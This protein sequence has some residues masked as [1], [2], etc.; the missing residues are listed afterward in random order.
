MEPIWIVLIVIG[1]ILLLPL[2]TI[3]FH[4]RIV[5]CFLYKKL[6]GR[7]AT[8]EHLRSITATDEIQL[9]EWH[10]GF[11]FF[12]RIKDKAQ[13]VSIVHDGLTLAGMYFDF[14]YE[15]T[16][17]VVPGRMESAAYSLYF[18]ELYEGQKVNLL[19]IDNRGTG[20]S[21]GSRNTLGTKESGDLIEW[22]KWLGEKNQKVFLHGICIGGAQ[23]VYALSNPSCPNNVI[24]GLTEGLFKEFHSMFAGHLTIIKVKEEP[25]ST[26]VMEKFKKYEG[27][28]VFVQC[29]L[30]AVDKIKVPMRFIQSLEDR[31]ILPGSA[32]ELCKKCGSSNKDFI[33]FPYGAHS[34]VRH[35]QKEEYDAYVLAYLN[36]LL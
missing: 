20:Y 31:F 28:D 24:G 3:P 5:A 21:E 16:V 10:E 25:T 12:E 36:S 8:D 14:G 29:P 11:R 9:E 32:E 34:R 7:D 27:I 2:A 35:G 30:N 23:V 1:S 6:F 18:A 22:I 15:T 19:L 4:E 13:E 17:I 26:Y 33:Y